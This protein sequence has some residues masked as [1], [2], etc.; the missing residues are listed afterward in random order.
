[1]MV[2]NSESSGTCKTCEW[3]SPSY[4]GGLCTRTNKKTKYTGHCDHYAKKRK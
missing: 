1:M 2:N 4:K 3:C